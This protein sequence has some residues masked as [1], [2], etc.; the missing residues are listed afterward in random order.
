ME[1]LSPANRIWWRALIPLANTSMWKDSL[2]ALKS[3]IL[4]PTRSFLCRNS[5][6]AP[7]LYPLA[8]MLD[9]TYRMLD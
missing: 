9:P 6:A 3:R 5:G 2:R 4:I 7:I 1:F 8:L